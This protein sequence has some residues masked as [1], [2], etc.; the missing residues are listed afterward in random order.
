MHSEKS[1]PD[2]AGHGRI[3]R[4]GNL[5][6]SFIEPSVVTYDA[7]SVVVVASLGNCNPEGWTNLDAKTNHSVLLFS[8]AVHVSS[9]CTDADTA[10]ELSGTGSDG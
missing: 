5:G 1:G 6:L 2:A 3:I 4:T 7:D 8:A 10:I 9:G